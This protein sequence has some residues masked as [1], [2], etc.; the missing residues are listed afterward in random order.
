MGGWHGVDFDGTLA[1]YPNE[2]DGWPIPGKPIPLMVSRVKRWLANG[3]DVR[4]ITARVSDPSSRRKHIG[5]IEEWCCV[6][7]GQVLEVT[8][9]KDFEMIDVWDD[10]AVQVVP[11]TGWRVDG[12]EDPGE[13][14]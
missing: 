10:R 12:K 6:H 7:I 8:C 3:E 9:S 11:N 4:I 5:L 14:I 2:E 1:Q 13:K